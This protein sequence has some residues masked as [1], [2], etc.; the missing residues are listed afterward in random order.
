MGSALRLTVVGP[1]GQQAWTEVSEEF[2]QTDRALSRFRDDAELVALDRIAGI[3]AAVSVSRRLERAVHTTER[4]RR[5]TGGRFDPR[6]LTDLERIG[7]RG[8]DLGRRHDRDRG[9]RLE[10]VWRYARR[11]HIALDRP[12]DLGGIGKG[13]A[14]RWATARVERTGVHDLLIDAG[15]DVVVRGRAPDGGPWRIGIE[16]PLDRVSGVL[17]VICTTD[18][19]IATSSISRRHWDRDGTPV[20][21]VIDPVSGEPAWTGLQAVTIAGPDPAWAEVW[22]KTLFL[23]GAHEIGIEARSRGL[24]AWWVDDAGT[25]EMT[26]AGRA[27]TR[28]VRGED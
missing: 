4:A 3:G 12:I 14:L 13:L 10:P 15:G 7:E 11:G 26:P 21:H 18:E 19:A 9:W 8:A 2:D 28:W 5:L 25:L 20:H 22:S 16:D 17:A 1:G 24:A 27:R 6:V 23:A